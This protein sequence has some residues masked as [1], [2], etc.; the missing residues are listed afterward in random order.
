MLGLRWLFRAGRG[1]PFG[2]PSEPLY[3]R[4]K[5]DGKKPKAGGKGKEKKEAAPKE[6]D[7]KAAA[8]K[9]GA[10]AEKKPAGAPAEEEEVFVEKKKKIEVPVFYKD[11]AKATAKE[12]YAANPPPRSEKRMKKFRQSF[13]TLCTRYFGTNQ[14]LDP[15]RKRKG[16][17][18]VIQGIDASKPATYPDWM[19]K[20]VELFG[21]KMRW[22][23]MSV[24]D[25]KYWKLKRR[26]EIKAWNASQLTEV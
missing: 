2:M 8:A 5:G 4:A 6:G 11:G 1:G 14:Q 13:S 18:T 24:R 3:L 26:S 20:A 25:P 16:V 15:K 12:A 10:A 21:K 19:Y 23:D 7:A 22:Q 9:P 17:D